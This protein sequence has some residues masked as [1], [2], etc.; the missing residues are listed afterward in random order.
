VALTGKKQSKS[1]SAATPRESKKLDSRAY[2]LG[3]LGGKHFS[4]TK[5]KFEK[6]SIP[7]R[8]ETF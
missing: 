2:E 3:T 4:Y 6:T 8:K 7:K 5:L 1:N